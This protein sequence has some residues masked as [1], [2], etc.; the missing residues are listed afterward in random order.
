M[1]E[2]LSGRKAEVLID[3]T[4]MLTAQEWL[5]VA[6]EPN[7]YNLPEKYIL[8]YFLG[9]KTFGLQREIGYYANELD[10]E[11]VDLL[12]ESNQ[13]LYSAGPE[14]FVYL[15]AN[16]KLVL[17]DSFHACVFS[18]LF[19][20][21]FLVYERN[22]INKKNMMSR[23]DT[24]LET[25]DLRRKFRNSGLDNEILEANY[26]KGYRALETEREKVKKYISQ[27]ESH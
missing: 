24:L 14:V 19:Q 3:P 22:E 4:L 11:V 10:A 5:E 20:K 1:V 25:F 23:I 21:P 13:K 15:I 18:F 12:D 16:A 26:E 8:T 2:K 17:T 6:E 27:L 9:N 7:G